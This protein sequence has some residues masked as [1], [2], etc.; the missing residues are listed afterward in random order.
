VNCFE[1]QP[2]D[3]NGLLDILADA[4]IA[5][6][7]NQVNS[8]TF[9]TSN[10]DRSSSSGDEAQQID[11]VELGEGDNSDGSEVSLTQ[12]AGMVYL[13][14]SLFS[15]DLAKKEIQKLKAIL[16]S[17]KRRKRRRKAKYRTML[18]KNKTITVRHPTMAK[19]M[20]PTLA[21]KQTALKL[22]SPRTMRH[23]S[24]MSWVCDASFYASAVAPKA[25]PAIQTRRRYT[26]VANV[27]LT[28]SDA[29]RDAPNQLNNR[30]LG[31][32]HATRSPIIARRSGEQ[33]VDLG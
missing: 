22:Q 14:T 5:A 30:S 4:A 25:A 23:G 13:L 26:F 18:L 17:S 11:Q 19:A 27:S 32:G 1:F 10:E 16:M 9:V 3:T 20:T 2:S 24:R 33:L 31:V 6:Q 7:T 29:T 15:R 12:A 8:V 28:Y 21:M